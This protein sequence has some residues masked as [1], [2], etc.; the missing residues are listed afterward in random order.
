MSLVLCSLFSRYL[1]DIFLSFPPSLPSFLFP[2]FPPLP[3]FLPSLSFPPPSTPPFLPSFFLY[4]FSCNFTGICLDV[5]MLCALSVCR[6]TFVILGKFSV[7]M[8]FTICSAFYF[9]FYLLSS[10]TILMLKILPVFNI[11]KFL[12]N[13]FLF[14]IPFW[15]LKL[16][17][18]SPFI[19]LNLSSV[20]FV[21]YCYFLTIFLLLFSCICGLL[22]SIISNYFQ[23]MEHCFW[24]FLVLIYIV[25]F[26]SCRG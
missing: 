8:G 16:F 25:S 11:L 15:F 24:N 26:M 5:V 18:L 13:L 12:L 9:G 20:V 7:V 23:S 17:S 6:L 2:S 3:F 14:L 4:S 21:S 22:F 10:P 19:L 1:K